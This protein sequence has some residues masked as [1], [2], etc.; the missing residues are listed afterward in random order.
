MTIKSVLWYQG[1]NNICETPQKQTLLD[2]YSCMEPF[3]LSQWR[4]EWSIIPKTTNKLFPFGFVTLAGGT[5][6]GCQ[7]MPQFRLGQTALYNY[8]PNIVLPNTFVAFAHDLGDPFSSQCWY[9]NPCACCSWGTPYSWNE[10]EYY[11]G[12]IY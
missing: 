12:S 9:Q 8:I 4:N 2:G 7:Q 6:E 11:M 3:M 1:E 10:T 5:D